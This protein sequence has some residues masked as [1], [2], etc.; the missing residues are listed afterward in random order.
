MWFGNVMSVWGWSIYYGVIEFFF[1]GDD[2]FY[3]LLLL[4]GDGEVIEKK[5]LDLVLKFVELN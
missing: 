1:C 2:D 4:Y 3:Y 5:Y